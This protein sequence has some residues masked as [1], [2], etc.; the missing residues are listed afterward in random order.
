MIVFD[1]NKLDRKRCND[2]PDFI[3]EIVSPTNPSDDYIRKLYYYENAGVREY[4][5]VDPHRK[6]VTV[7][8]LKKMHLTFNILLNLLSK[9]I[10]SMICLSIFLKFLIPLVLK[11]KEQRKYRFYFLYF[12][13]LFYF[14]L[15]FSLA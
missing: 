3:I 9:F 2:A 12:I 7:H 15:F 6:I 11:Q 13:A 4:W 1:T 14:Y 5:I 8:F 10:F